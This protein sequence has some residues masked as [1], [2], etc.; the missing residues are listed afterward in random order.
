MSSYFYLHIEGFSV[1]TL[2]ET[3]PDAAFLSMIYS[4]LCHRYL[5]QEADM[6]EQQYQTGSEAV[7]KY[8][9]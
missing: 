2:R 1:I 5:I 6:P 9:L 3:V 4:S 7:M 8:T